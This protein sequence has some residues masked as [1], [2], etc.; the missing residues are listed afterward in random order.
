MRD[1]EKQ[2][3]EYLQYLPTI[4]REAAGDGTAT[5]EFLS[6]LLLGLQ[7]ILTGVKNNDGIEDDKKIQK[8]KHAPEYEPLEAVIDQLDRFFDPFRTDP[9]FL[10]WLASWVALEP[11]PEWTRAERRKMIARMVQV[12]RRI[13]MKAGLYDYLDVYARESLRPRVSIDD[14]EAV[15]RVV[16]RGDAPAQVGV[17]AFAQIFQSGNKSTPILYRPTAIAVLE[18][19]DKKPENVRYVV[20]DAGEVWGSYPPDLAPCLWVLRPNGELDDAHWVT[21]EPRTGPPSPRPL[22][23][24]AASVQGQET[25]LLSAPVAVVPEGPGSLLVLDQGHKYGR[26]NVNALPCI[27]R[28]SRSPA[29]F[30]REQVKSLGQNLDDR[31][32]IGM[33]LVS[34]DANKE[35]QLVVLD[36]AKKKTPR[37]LI[38]GPVSGKT[39]AGQ[40]AEVKLAEI[41]LKDK[42]GKPIV[43]TPTAIVQDGES[44]G[45]FV[46]ADACDDETEAPPGAL[47]RVK[48]EK[49]GDGTQWSVRKLESWRLEHEGNVLVYP[50]CLA[51][52]R[53]GLPRVRRWLQ[54]VGIRVRGHP[55]E[56]RARGAVPRVSWQG[57]GDPGR[58]PGLP[59]WPDEPLE[60]GLRQP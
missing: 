25:D 19:A 34:D 43:V 6:N 38:I 55:D 8:T 32:P 1:A 45:I 52:G 59:R 18:T 36:H 11:E 24:E 10:D 20:A 41:E 49:S 5:G 39:A 46:I 12:S 31:H 56:G 44:A 16:L 48:I 30:A 50:T 17:L 2:P 58:A 21:S 51:R 4:F 54:A 22:N 7:K 60:H 9:R 40:P 13:G 57:W 37:L 23:R 33:V 3:S 14:D 47:V 42:A 26:G 29:G 35:K 28:Y 27:F 15:F 53:R